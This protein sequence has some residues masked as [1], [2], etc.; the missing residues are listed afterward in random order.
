[1]VKYYIYSITLFISGIPNVVLRT[2][3]N[4]RV[5]DYLKAN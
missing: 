5:A 4:T 2:V 1:M 3:I